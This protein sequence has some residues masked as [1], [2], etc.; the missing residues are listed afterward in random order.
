MNLD[1]ARARLQE[2]DDLDHHG[3][4]G[5]LAREALD[6]LKPDVVA[7]DHPNNRSYEPV[8]SLAEQI[9]DMF[10]YDG[11][12]GTTKPR[13]QAGGNGTKQEEARALAREELLRDGHKPA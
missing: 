4:Y 10:V 13:W 11:P 1:I 3:R 9:Y 8:E 12:A 6:A 5:R 7:W 2:I